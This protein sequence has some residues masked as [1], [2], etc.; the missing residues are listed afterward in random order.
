MR[1]N[2]YKMYIKYTQNIHKMFFIIQHE[3]TQN[4]CQI[5]KQTSLILHW[6]LINYDQILAFITQYIS[7]A[8]LDNIILYN[9]NVYWYD[10]LFY[11]SFSLNKSRIS[12]YFMIIYHLSLRLSRM[13]LNILV[14]RLFFSRVVIMLLIKSRI[15]SSNISNI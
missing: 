12:L 11:F 9:I 8:F 5:Y 1:W 7:I 4:S 10:I 2:S 3:F 14:I 15:L 6:I 13:F